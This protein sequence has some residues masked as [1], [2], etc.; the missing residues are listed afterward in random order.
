M[1]TKESSSNSSRRQFLLK[2]LTAGTML[3]FGCQSLFAA[4]IHS[5]LTKSTIKS[6]EDTDNK[7]MPSEDVVRFSLDYCVP[8]LQ[9]I[10]SKIGKDKFIEMLRDASAENITETVA[11]AT[12]GMPVK[13]MKA[14]S[15]FLEGFLSTPPF[16]KTYAFEIVEKTDKVYELKYTK[17][18][19][20]EIYRNKNAADIGYAVE[21]LPTVA[22][23]RAFNS[24]IKTV[25][26]A[27][28]MKGDSFCTLRFELET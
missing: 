21:C 16:D 7:G 6:S 3:C 22:A 27:N 11:S 17:C 25:N 13:D 12:Q 20:A 23:A 1:E 26:T 15:D 8:I 28:M 18:L 10:E 2:N 9:K 4:D 24:K 14:F 19:M 5:K